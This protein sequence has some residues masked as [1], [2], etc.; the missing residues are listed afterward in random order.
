MPGLHCQG[1]EAQLV[2][3]C[4]T[5]EESVIARA[6]DIKSMQP[7]FQGQAKDM[8]DHFEDVA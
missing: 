3:D 6:G 2:V 7:D 8:L 5:F 4:F 1:D